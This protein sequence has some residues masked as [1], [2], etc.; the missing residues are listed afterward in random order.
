MKFFTILLFLSIILSSCNK[1]QENET[2]KTETTVTKSEQK[3]FEVES[4]KCMIILQP[5]EE[6]MKKAADK[7]KKED[8]SEVASDAGMYLA[9]AQDFGKAKG[10]KIVT[11][12]DKVIIFKKEDGSTFKLENNE[13]SI[14]GSIYFFDGKKNPI[15]VETLAS[16]SDGKEYDAY[17][18]VSLHPTIKQL[19]GNWAP[20]SMP[21]M[22]T[23]VYENDMLLMMPNQKFKVK[24]EGTLITYTPLENATEKLTRKIKT[25]NSKEFSFYENGN[26]L[27]K[28]VKVK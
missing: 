17:F 28:M 23:E 18:G 24:V 5:N 10:L 22:F 7:M 12:E 19:Q 15:K 27:T 25:L 2:K 3:D 6:N 14:S 26:S 13:E 9:D 8:L 20:V 21:E 11:S 4:C 16:I 1:P